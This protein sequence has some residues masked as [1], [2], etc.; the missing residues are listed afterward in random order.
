MYSV[1]VAE[2]DGSTM[3]GM[4]S[5]G[6]CAIVPIGVTISGTK[7]VGVRVA[8]VGGGMNRVGVGESVPIGTTGSAT[9]VFGVDAATDGAD[10]GS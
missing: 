4:N 8:V 10:P 9:K 6:G 2:L 7:I 1:G 3:L 5:V